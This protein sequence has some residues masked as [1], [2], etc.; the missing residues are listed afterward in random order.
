MSRT[1]SDVGRLLREF[2]EIL[3]LCPHCGEVNRLSDLRLS[4]R[5]VPKRT[6]LD[7]LDDEDERL[8]KAEDRLDA[9][10][11]ELRAVASAAG[12]KAAKK[13]L[14]RIDPVFSGSGL[15]PQDVK[16]IFDPVEYVVFRGDAARDI[17]EILLVAEPPSSSASERAKDSVAAAVR[18]GNVEFATLRVTEEGGIER[19][20]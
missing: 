4:T 8:A 19:K 2:G 10:E 17:R 18:K 13:R 7:L 14:R 5:G 3:C 15:D 9:R 6:A 12:A 11:Q 16:L 1:P 20:E